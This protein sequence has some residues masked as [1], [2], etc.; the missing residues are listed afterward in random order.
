MA[1][2]IETNVEGSLM[3][4]GALSTN[5]QRPIEVFR[6]GKYDFTIRDTQLGKPIKINYLENE[7]GGIGHFET[8]GT[9]NILNST[10]PTNCLYDACIRNAGS[11][12]K[13][14]CTLCRR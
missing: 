5:L 6:N 3:V 13:Q 14:R 8:K 4:I 1:K 12:S 2:N 11:K 7:N 9:Y 10:S